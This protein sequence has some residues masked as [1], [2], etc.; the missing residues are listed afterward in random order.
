MTYPKNNAKNGRLTRAELRELVLNE[1]LY[2]G[3]VE[4]KE[5][6]FL[7]PI[8]TK[9]TVSPENPLYNAYFMSSWILDVLRYYY[10]YDNRHVTIMNISTDL[11]LFADK[12]FRIYRERLEY[13]RS[14]LWRLRENTIR[15]FYSKAPLVLL[16][17]RA[18]ITG[19]SCLD[20]SAFMFVIQGYDV[21]ENMR[22]I[23]KYINEI[24]GIT[25]YYYPEKNKTRLYFHDC[26][27][28]K[29]IETVKSEALKM[30]QKL[31]DGCYIELA[32]DQK[33]DIKEGYDYGKKTR[34]YYR[35]VA[36]RKAE[37]NSKPIG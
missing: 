13:G 17:A 29:L 7:T 27:Y 3:L 37:E 31:Y 21:E 4:G 25:N 18:E 36:R 10:R 22:A 16:F 35:N 6:T 28:E 12:K 23:S 20:F 2:F 19:Q 9:S 1:A 24:C 15:Y 33:F 11:A 32:E 8:V 14:H 30:K 5:E 26:D 34:S